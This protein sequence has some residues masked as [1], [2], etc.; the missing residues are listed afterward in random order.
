MKGFLIPPP[1]NIMAV[2]PWWCIPM[3]Q[4]SVFR[5]AGIQTWREDCAG[6]QD[7]DRCLKHWTSHKTAHDSQLF[8]FLLLNHLSDFSRKSRRHELLLIMQTITGE[9]P[10]EFQTE[11]LTNT[12]PLII[13]AWR[14]CWCV[15]VCTC[16]SGN[17]MSAS[18]EGFTVKWKSR[19][20]S[21]FE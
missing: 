12:V 21:L 8:T 3:C 16:N 9:M 14:V 1:P 5:N 4:L 10:K 18:F 15:R 13:Y 11:V 17:K 20:C 19:L 6:Q 2:L 7:A